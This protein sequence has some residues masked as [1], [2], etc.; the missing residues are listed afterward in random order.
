MTSA[1][2]ITHSGSADSHD[3]Q[4]AKVSYDYKVDGKAY[5]AARVAFGDYTSGNASH[6]SE[7][8][9][10]YPVGAKV[11]VYYSPGDPENAVLETGVHPGVWIGIGVGAIM[12]AVGIM[13]VAIY[14]AGSKTGGFPN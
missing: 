3:T 14:R 11:A 2:I 4:G 6:A 1:E 7:V 8:L 9:N 13:I 5:S 10:R 12:F